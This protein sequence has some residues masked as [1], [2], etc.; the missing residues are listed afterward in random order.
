MALFPWYRPE[1]ARQARR[2]ERLESTGFGDR[3]TPPSRLALGGRLDLFAGVIVPLAILLFL[4]L[5]GL[6]LVVQI[7]L[8]LGAVAAVLTAILRSRAAHRR[9]EERARKR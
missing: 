1:E 7:A 3:K 5:M 6:P 9:A 8:G 2:V 4:L